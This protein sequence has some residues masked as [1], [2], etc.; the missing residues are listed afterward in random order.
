VRRELRVAPQNMKPIF[1]RNAGPG[2]TNIPADANPKKQFP[3]RPWPK[4]KS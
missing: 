3:V 2:K 4:R 1:S